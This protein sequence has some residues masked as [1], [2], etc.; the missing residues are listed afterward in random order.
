MLRYHAWSSVR[1][2]GNIRMRVGVTRA[3]TSSSS[4]PPNDL[5]APRLSPAE[6]GPYLATNLADFKPDVVRNF[7][8]VAHIDH[9]KSVRIEWL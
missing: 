2:R 1:G 9:G 6:L 4:A 3:F 7:S 8:I 5:P